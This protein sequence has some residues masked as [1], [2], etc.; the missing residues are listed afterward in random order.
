MKKEAKCSLDT[1]DRSE[2]WITSIGLDNVV[3]PSL[4][5]GTEIE[6][7]AGITMKIRLSC[8]GRKRFLSI[9]SNPFVQLMLVDGDEQAWGWGG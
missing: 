6:N 4:I 3:F 5:S 7:E 2:H 1:K 9:L 8:C